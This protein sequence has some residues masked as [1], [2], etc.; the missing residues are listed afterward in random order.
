MLLL[1]EGDAVTEGPIR[2]LVVDDSAFARKVIREVH[3]NGDDIEVVGTARDG[4]DALEKIAELTPD[5]VTLDLVMPNLDGLGVLRALGAT[6]SPPAV[7]V[8][9]MNN[10]DSELG[11]TALEL[12]ATDIVTKP[13]ALATDRLYELGDELRAKVLA[14]ARR[15]GRPERPI[16][17]PLRR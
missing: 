8:V 10:E 11:V 9:S 6:K 16:L 15:R 7:I 3:S 12:G 4:L 2:V 14:V 13:T 5:V 1:Q 17:W